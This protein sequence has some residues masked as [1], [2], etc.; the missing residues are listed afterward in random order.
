MTRFTKFEAKIEEFPPS[1][2]L[3]EQLNT[4][5]VEDFGFVGERVGRRKGS[6]LSGFVAHERTIDLRE[7]FYRHGFRDLSLDLNYRR[8][9]AKATKG[10]IVR[11]NPTRD[12]PR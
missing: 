12:I 8:S 1:Q 5:Q 9:R 7:I 3:L 6:R 11:D 2:E 10:K 4:A